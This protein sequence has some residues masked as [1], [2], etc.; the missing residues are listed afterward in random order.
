MIPQSPMVLFPISTAA[1]FRCSQAKVQV[2]QL[3]AQLQVTLGAPEYYLNIAILVGFLDW[4]V[5]QDI[6]LSSAM[7]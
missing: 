4:V 6:R 1:K 7:Y 3:K 5:K 2:E